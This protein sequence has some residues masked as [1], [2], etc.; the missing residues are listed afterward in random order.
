MD[1][2]AEKCL[3][4]DL[5][6][7]GSGANKQRVARVAVVGS[8]GVT[9]DGGH[10]TITADC[11]SAGAL[12]RE[13]ER[14]HGELDDAL[15]RGSAELA[16]STY[17]PRPRAPRAASADAGP[18][19]ELP[20][21]SITWSVADVMTREVQTVDANEPVAAAKALMDAGN[22][23]HIVVVGADGAIEG[24]V[25]QRDLFF[26]PLAWSIGQGKA[27]YEKLLRSSHVKDVMHSDVATIDASAPLQQA[28]A[29]LD[30]RKIGCL[31][32]VERDRLVG[33]VTEG[34]FVRL[35]ANASR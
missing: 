15:A 3:D 21:L 22:F 8:W 7:V 1:E 4:L 13:I 25:S 31:P 28:A 11:A 29:L 9:R 17:V 30:E 5:D 12:E 2:A 23:R 16:A 34:D 33:L 10:A 35:F 27:A 24:V 20:R 32:V 26:G 6:A 14:L 18:A 19:R